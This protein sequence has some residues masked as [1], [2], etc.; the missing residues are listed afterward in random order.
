M[1][2]KI[3][4]VPSF[5]LHKATGQA[6]AVFESKRRYFGRHELPES[7]ARY[8]QAVAEWLANG[9][10]ARV[11]AHDLT[12][13]ELVN[14]F[15]R[16]CES[17]SID[18]RDAGHFKAAW[19]PIVELYGDTP[20]AAFGP[21]KLKAVRERLIAGPRGNRSRRYVNGLAKRIRYIFKWAVAEEL[22]PASVLEA[23]RAVAGLRPGKGGEAVETEPVKPVPQEHID[24]I[25]PYLSKQVEAIIDLQLLTAARPGELV[26]MRPIDI[27]TTGKV[28]VYTPKDHKSAWRGHHRTIYLGPKAQEIV[29]PFLAGR[30]VEAFLFSPAEAVEKQ[31]EDR[32]AARVTPLSCGNKPGSNVERHPQ[33]TPGERYT[34]ESYRHAIQFACKRAGIDK[35]HPYQLRHN[36]ATNLR[37]QFGVDVAA[38][39]LG[40][41]GLNTIEVYAEKNHELAMQIAG[42]VG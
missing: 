41:V 2:K 30:A 32:H 39:L 35:W 7:K 14:A 28:W 10:C 26:I 13:V 40:H 20:A 11:D 21:L 4:D 9:R 22:V 24:A 3:P 19:T 37:K 25:R 5:K 34:P 27:D 15:R 12:I 33:R 18:K 36:A 31:R 1:T 17:E 29:Q 23:L 42:K 6:Y 16:R 38:T 8:D